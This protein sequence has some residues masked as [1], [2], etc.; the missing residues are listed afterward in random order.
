MEEGWADGGWIQ[1]PNTSTPEQRCP[2]GGT[3]GHEAGWGELWV[4]LLLQT[5]SVRENGFE[6]GLNSWFLP[7]PAFPQKA[8]EWCVSTNG[9]RRA[10]RSVLSCTLSATAWM[11]A[12]PLGVIAPISKASLL[13]GSPAGR[14]WDLQ[15][16]EKLQPRE[17]ADG[18]GGVRCV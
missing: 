15:A 3:C 14:G 17:L 5:A 4:P 9:E 10:S 11:D 13:Q 8:S 12:C 2:Y 16:L 18:S 6:S 1:A 7:S